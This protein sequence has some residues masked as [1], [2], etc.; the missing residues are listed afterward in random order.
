[1]DGRYIERVVERC[2]RC[3]GKRRFPLARKEDVQVD[4]QQQEEQERRSAKEPLPS[5]HE[6]DLS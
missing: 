5:C 4:C 3:R 2:V 1:T 6:F